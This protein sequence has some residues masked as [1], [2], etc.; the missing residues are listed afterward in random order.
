VNYFSIRR[1]V[2]FY[3]TDAMAVV[4]HSNYFRFFE[5]ARGAWVRKEGLADALWNEK[6]IGFAVIEATCRFLR[7]AAHGDE[8]EVRLQVRREGIRYRFQY[9]VLKIEAGNPKSP[10]NTKPDPL[11]KLIDG[12]PLLVTGITVHVPLNEEMKPCKVPQYF[13]DTVE[14]SSWTETWP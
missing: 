11:G 4:H 13:N 12:Y 8:I 10:L 9:A 14:K 2:T 1:R 3:E 6:N 7:P 5:E